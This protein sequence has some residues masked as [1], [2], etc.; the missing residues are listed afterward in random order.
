M[1]CRNQELPYANYLEDY[2]ILCMSQEKSFLERFQ[3]Y[4][5]SIAELGIQ[6]AN[7]VDAASGA[8][9]SEGLRRQQALKMFTKLAR[10][11]IE[12]FRQEEKNATDASAL[13]RHYKSLLRD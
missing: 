6:R 10:K 8:L 13:I 5:R 7:T 4:D 3:N 11:R 12:L 9:K 1:A 2:K